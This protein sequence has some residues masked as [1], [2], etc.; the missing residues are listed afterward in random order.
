MEFLVHGATDY[1]EPGVFMTFEETAADL[2]ENVCSLG[3]DLDALI[4]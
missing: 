3:F 4:K 1:D 2:S